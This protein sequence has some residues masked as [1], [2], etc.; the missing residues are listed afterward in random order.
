MGLGSESVN[1]V[2][3]GLL[4]DAPQTCRVTK[5]AVMELQRRG[6]RAETLAQM[7][8]ASGREA[9][10]APDDTMDLVAAVEQEL[11]QVGA[12]LTGYSRD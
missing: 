4:D 11:G 3:A 8:D 5:V 10:T 12:I 2:G 1:F 9:G 7:V 6:A